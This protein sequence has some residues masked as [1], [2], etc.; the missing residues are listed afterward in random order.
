MQ[1]GTLNGCAVDH[2]TAWRTAQV[3]QTLSVRSNKLRA[4]RRARRRALQPMDTGSARRGMDRARRAVR[5]ASDVRAGL[6]AQQQLRALLR[7][8]TTVRRSD[9]RC[10]TSLGDQHRKRQHR[11]QNAGR[12]HGADASICEYI[13]LPSMGTSA[14]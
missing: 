2:P 13:T 6:R 3:S 5:L 7:D 10:V 14:T 1:L 12:F 11:A 4:C 9:R 8:S